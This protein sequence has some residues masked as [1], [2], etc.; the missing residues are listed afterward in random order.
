M[1]PGGK[2]HSYVALGDLLPAFLSSAAAHRAA[3]ALQEQARE[4]G[5]HAVLRR[6]LFHLFLLGPDTHDLRPLKAIEVI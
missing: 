3:H 6:L 2:Q 4:H 5:R 1:L